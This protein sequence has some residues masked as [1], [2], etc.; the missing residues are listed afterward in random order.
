M[1]WTYIYPQIKMNRPSM[2]RLKLCELS[3]NLMYCNNVIIR[4][5]MV[6]KVT[7]VDAR[8]VDIFFPLLY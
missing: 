1:K 3:E 7:N 6:K 4:I 2:H 5:P 8:N